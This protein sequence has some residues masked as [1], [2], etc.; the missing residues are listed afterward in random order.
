MCYYRLRINDHYQ[1]DSC[2]VEASRRLPVIP[3]HSC[4]IADLAAVPP[5]SGDWVTG[6]DLSAG[7]TKRWIVSFRTGGAE[8][9]CPARDLGSFPLGGCEP[10]RRFSWG[11]GQRHRPR[12]PFRLKFTTSG[13]AAEHVPD[14]LAITGDGTWLFDVRPAER[15]GDDDR[16][17]FAASAELALACRWRYLLVTGWRRH[18]MATLDAFSSQRRL[19]GDP[20]GMRELWCW[21]APSGR[22]TWWNRSTA[23]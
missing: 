5:A 16:A 23:W 8:V 21:M 19:I 6:L 3:S 22:W 18:A 14:V 4:G 2:D 9:A 15:I 1:C 13:G 7:W 12:Q 11:R 17:K 10:V 20:L